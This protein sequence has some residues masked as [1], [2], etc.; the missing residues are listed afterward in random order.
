MLAVWLRADSG[1]EEW[2][3]MLDIWVYYVGV[4]ILIIAGGIVMITAFLG[5][6][7]AL[8]ESKLGLTVVSRHKKKVEFNFLF[9]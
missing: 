1:F 2:V 4:Y 5:C 7:A 8:T 6:C 3:R 9:S